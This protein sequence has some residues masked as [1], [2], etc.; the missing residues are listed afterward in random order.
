[1]E[2]FDNFFQGISLEMWRRAFTPEMT[3]SEVDFLMA[4]LAVQ[5]GSEVLDVPC[6]NG[7]HSIELAR[8]GLRVTGVDLSTEFMDEARRESAAQG[9]DVAWH[10]GDMRELPWVGAFEGAF[11]WGNSFGYFDDPSSRA[12]VASIARALRPGARLIVDYGTTAES[13]LPT[14]MQPRQWM[15]FDD[16]LMLREARYDAGESRLD[17]DYTFIRG[18]ERDTRRASYWLETVAELKR[19]LMGAGLM[20]ESL[21][22]GIDRKAFQLGSPQLI[23]VARRT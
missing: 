3:C 6:G 16:I 20:V 17:T 14:A 10:H 19:K 21:F 5:A 15:Q 22:S 18:A 2:W 8:R 11:C 13:I 9:L 7:R 1:M 4:E 12:F 23:A